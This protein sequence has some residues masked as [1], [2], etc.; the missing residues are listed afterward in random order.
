LILYLIAAILLLCYGVVVIARAVYNE[1]KGG[2]P[3]V[4]GVI[5]I[6]LLTGYNI[7]AYER[8]LESNIL[9]LSVGYILIFSC[10]TVGVLQHLGIL[11]TDQ[12][13][14]YKLTYND[15]YKKK[16]K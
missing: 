6:V 11:K 15:L 2:F 8:I 5:L 16:E 14:A 7:I 1:T 3:L 12:A 9:L 4:I 10:V 13:S